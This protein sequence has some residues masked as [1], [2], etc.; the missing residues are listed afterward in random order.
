MAIAVTHLA[1]VGVVRLTIPPRLVVEERQAA[2]ASVTLCVVS[3]LT[4]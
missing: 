1:W 2:V 4:N 3:T